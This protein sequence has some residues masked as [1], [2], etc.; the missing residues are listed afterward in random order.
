MG[1]GDALSPLLFNVALEEALKKTRSTPGGA[2]IPEKINLLA[3]ADDVA[4]IAE[5]K[6]DLIDLAKVLLK[7]A[8]KVGLK[9][10][11]EKTNNM[12]ISRNEDKENFP[13]RN[14]E[15]LRIPISQC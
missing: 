9:V 5:N 6:E 3:F 7:V 2:K 11:E 10:N 12:K 13:V 1:Q 4:I 14:Q 15:H 8:S